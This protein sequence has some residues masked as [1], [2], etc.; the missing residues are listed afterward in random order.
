MESLFL[1]NLTSPPLLF[2]FLGAAAA[3]VRSDLEIPAPVAKFLSLYLLFAIGFK[4]GVALSGDALDGRA[5]A[6]LLAALGLAAAVPLYAFAILKRRLGIADAAALA[7]TY[8]SISAVTFVTATSYLDGAGIAW[9]GHLVAAMAL[10][11]SPAIIIGILLYRLYGERGPGEQ[12]GIDWREL[13][14]ESCL[15]GSVFLI[16]GSMLIG[17]ITGQRGMTALAPFVGELFTGMLCLFLLDMGIVAARRLR[18]MRLGRMGLGEG[19]GI[20]FLFGFA[21]LFPLFNAV[22]AGSI[23]TLLGLPEGDAL[24]LTVLGASASYI[25]VPAALRL[26]LPEANPSLYL[27]M[28]LAVTFPFNLLVGIPLYHQVLRWL[29]SS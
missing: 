24:L 27:P 13:G 6:G 17:W 5:W 3:L 18:D 8:G 4:G 19:A 21:I 20:P 2:F 1:V 11:E 23:A 14:R 26:A 15:N 12:A 28:S 7:A 25:A 10:M 9:G 16:V 22:V 29:V